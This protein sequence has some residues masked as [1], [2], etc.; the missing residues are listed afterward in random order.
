VVL[1]QAMS[2]AAAITGSAACAGAV[3]SEMAATTSNVTTQS[4]DL[5][6]TILVLISSLTPGPA[7]CGP[8]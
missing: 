2:P 6:P 3:V 1:A 8:R 5:P 4:G 7:S